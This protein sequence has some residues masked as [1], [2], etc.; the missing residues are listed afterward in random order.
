M[1]TRPRSAG[2]SGKVILVGAGPGD[3]DLIT[4]RGA[5][6]LRQADV[7][8]YDELAAKELLD[9]APPHVTRINAGKRGHGPPTHPQEE[10]TALLLRL[11]SEGKRVVR[12]KGGDP[13]VFGRGGEEASACVEAGVPFE[14]VPGVSSVLGALAYAGIPLTDRRHSAS[15]AVVTGHKDPTRVARETRWREL[16]GA[17][18]TLA[19]LMGM[20][21]LE[22]LLDKLMKG[23]RAPE[24]PAA[25]VMNGTLPSQRVVVSTLGKLAKAVVDAEIGAPAVVVIGDVVRLRESLNWFEKKPLFGKR[26]LVTRATGQVKGIVDALR[27]AGAEA[28]VVPMIALERPEDLATLDLSLARRANYDTVVL[29]SA[30]AVRFTEV[31]MEELGLSLSEATPPAACVGPITADAARRA[32]FDVVLTPEHQHDAKGLLTA[33]S[34]RWPLEGRRFWLPQAEGA[35]PVLAEGLR[36]AG[37][38]VAAVTVYRT[39]AAAVNGEALREQLLAGELDA[40]TFTSPSTA[41]YFAALLDDESRKAASS[42]VVAAIGPVTEEALAELGLVADVVPKRATMRDLVDALAQQISGK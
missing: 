36:E 3:P 9:L 19:I 14:V 17:A 23:G 33:L 27:E 18:D 12:L 2:R 7:V 11:A 41:K 1:S 22:E 21:G 15:F 30:N 29:T 28:V 42:C 34:E 10:T 4:V 26:V 40:L 6:A 39:V 20:R 8:V 32:G 31:R 16:A 37:A 24:T 38:T 5:N 13:Y 35:S 25:A